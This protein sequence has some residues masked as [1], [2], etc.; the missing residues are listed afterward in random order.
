MPLIHTMNS[1]IEKDEELISENYNL[2]EMRRGG[3][4]K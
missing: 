2:I 4:A 1:I 3:Y